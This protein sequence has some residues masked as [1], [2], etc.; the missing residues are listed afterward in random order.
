MC[1]NYVT[2]SGI[3]EEG[4]ARGKGA[5]RTTGECLFDAHC[6]VHLIASLLPKWVHL[7]AE[8]YF[9]S[10][11]LSPTPNMSKRFFFASFRG[12]VKLLVWGTR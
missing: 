6:G 9:S 11:V 8:I 2:E 7:Q 4:G 1:C 5:V 3:G 10:G 12:D